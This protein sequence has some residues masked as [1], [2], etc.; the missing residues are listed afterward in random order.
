MTTL[1][2]F[3]EDWLG[4]IFAPRETFAA[5]SARPAPRRAALA[6]VLL[7]LAWAGLY[8]W[9][10]VDGRAPTFTRWLPTQ[11]DRY[12]GVARLYVAPLL[13]VLWL[14]GGQL[15]HVLCGQRAP[16][17]ASLSVL[18]FA[19]AVPFSVA[20]L[21][22]DLTVYG[23]NGQ[24]GMTEAIR[25][26]GPIALLWALGLTA[27]GLRTLHRL[28]RGRALRNTLMVFILMGGPAAVLL[29]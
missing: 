12:Y 24:I 14:F 28:S 17:G 7:G 27:L 11:A 18:G 3:R 20:L 29:R 16:L 15:A 25:V 2:A 21:I 22:P 26:T 10:A 9:L 19:L 6:I 4:M 13:V 8:T 5:L 1:R 23:F